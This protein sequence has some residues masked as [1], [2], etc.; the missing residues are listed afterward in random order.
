LAFAWLTSVAA[1]FDL[2]IDPQQISAEKS[3]RRIAA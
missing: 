3:Q 1:N 2:I